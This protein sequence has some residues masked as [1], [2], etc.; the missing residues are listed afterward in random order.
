MRIPN[1]YKQMW[2]KILAELSKTGPAQCTLPLQPS[3][4]ALSFGIPNLGLGFSPFP[5]C[6]PETALQCMEGLGQ[7][8]LVC[9]MRRVLVR[10][11]S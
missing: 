3:T 5:Q 1:P 11:L 10:H 9:Q 8:V 6:H 2:R 7:T 4:L